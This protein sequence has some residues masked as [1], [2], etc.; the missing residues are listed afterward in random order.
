LCRYSAGGSTLYIECTSIVQHGEDKKVGGI[1]KLPTQ[2][3]KPPKIST[4]TTQYTRTY[5]PKLCKVPKL[6]I[7]RN[8]TQKI[9]FKVISPPARYDATWRGAL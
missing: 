6:R 5:P 1:P 7:I 9:L 2:L 8:E 4:Q 3:C